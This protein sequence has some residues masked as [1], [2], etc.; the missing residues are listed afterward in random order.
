MKTKTILLLFALVVFLIAIYLTL[1]WYDYRLL[2][3][4]MLFLYSNN[5]SQRISIDHDLSSIKKVTELQ[6]RFIKEL[7]KK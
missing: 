1:E 4:I 3:V 2:I 6:D 5:L 7:T